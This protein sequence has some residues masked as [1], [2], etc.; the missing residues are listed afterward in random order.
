ML[1]LVMT[2]LALCAAPLAAMAECSTHQAMSCGEGMVWDNDAR[3]CVKQVS[4]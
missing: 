4:S 2:T 3:T 1:K